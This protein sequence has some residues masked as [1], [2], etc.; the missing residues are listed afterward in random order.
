MWLHC[1]FYSDTCWPT[2]IGT[3][4]RIWAFT[5][6]DDVHELKLRALANKLIFPDGFFEKFEIRTQRDKELLK[7]VAARLDELPQTKQ[8]LDDPTI[9]ATTR[10]FPKRMALVIVA[11]V[12]VVAFFSFGA[13]TLIN[14]DRWFLGTYFTLLA[15]Y[16]G[17]KLFRDMRNLEPQLIVD[18]KGVKI[19][20]DQYLWS[21]IKDVTITYSSNT[22]LSLNTSHGEINTTI[23][24][25]EMSSFELK[26]RMNIY[27]LR[28]LK[29][30]PAG[31]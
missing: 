7:R 11:F 8:I 26:N 13:Y 15:I 3:R 9:P 20:K 28:F 19:K 21:E 29:A 27:Q 30:T 10:V 12:M 5:A 2:Y 6:V 25:L 18:D 4:W 23:D 24:G 14:S 22:W 31:G 16:C 1:S 17:V